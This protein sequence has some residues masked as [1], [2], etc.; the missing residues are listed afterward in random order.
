MAV[1]PL[2]IAAGASAVSG[3]VG[4]KGNMAASRQARAVGE[5]NAKV[6]ENEQV[7]VQR[8][9]AE[10]ERVLRTNSE[11]L[12]GNQVLMSS[13]SG[14]QIKGSPLS[15]LFDTYMSTEVDAAKIRHAGSVEEANKEAEAGMA[16]LNANAQAVAMEYNALGSLV[17]G[18]TRATTLLT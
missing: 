14:V 10:N 8:A 4:Y 1:N 5:Y 6:A 16:R 15:A 9:T 18:G 3:F 7:L 13:A 17:Q 11:R 12:L 2:M